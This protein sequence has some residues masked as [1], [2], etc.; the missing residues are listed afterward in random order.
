MMAAAFYAAASAIAFVVYAIDK[1]AAVH[2]RRRIRES[3]LHLLAL[4]GGWP[5]A[6]AAQ[7]L[8]RHKSRKPAFQRV[9]W[10][11]VVLN[12]AMLAC[13]FSERGRLGLSPW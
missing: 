7:R 5:G 6:L 13:L 3:T 4:V 2:G 11:T 10:T 8:L 1:S 12:C 9:Y